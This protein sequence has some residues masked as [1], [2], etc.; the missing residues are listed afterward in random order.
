MNTQE[1]KVIGMAGTQPIYD[2]Y[3]EGVTVAK[4]GKDEYEISI[5]QR[6]RFGGVRKEIKYNNTVIEY[7]EASA[8][9]IRNKKSKGRWD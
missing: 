2:N 7:A 3:G 9:T 4:I 6:P 1:R 8:Q 5:P